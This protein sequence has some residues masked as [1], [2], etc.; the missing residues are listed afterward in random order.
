MTKMP[1]YTWTP[2]GLIINR[3]HEGP[4]TAALAGEYI[5]GPVV[6]QVDGE[7][8]PRLWRYVPEPSNNR[9]ATMVSNALDPAR[10]SGSGSRSQTPVSA[11]VP[12]GIVAEPTVP[13]TNPQEPY[14]QTY[15]PPSP[16]PTPT[17][18]HDSPAPSGTRPHED[19]QRSGEVVVEPQQT[20][21]RHVHFRDGPDSEIGSQPRGP[22]IREGE[23]YSYV[24]PFGPTAG[25][26]AVE[27]TG[28]GG[29]R[30]PGREG[31]G[32][33]DRRASR[34]RMGSMKTP[35]DVSPPWTPED[36]AP[37]SSTQGDGSARSTRHSAR[38]PANQ[39]PEIAA[40]PSHHVNSSPGPPNGGRPH[41]AHP[42]PPVP[43][44]QPEHDDSDEDLQLARALSL[45]MSSHT[46]ELRDPLANAPGWPM[47]QICG[48]KPRNLTDSRIGF[49]FSCYG[50]EKAAQAVLLHRTRERR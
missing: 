30:R 24:R 48:N 39:Q 31:S 16:A 22:R 50:K 12:D 28:Q 21:E 43:P 6:V 19:G 8:V 10:D 38:T 2:N 15:H 23:G 44:R 11:P 36:V 5:T 29:L 32:S 42:G 13:S 3:E 46:N 40:R 37:P 1:M 49:C 18:G 17:P 4:P 14:L 9:T 27:E 20:T 41:N 25:S 47:C 26:S 45:S 35:R 33:T 34:R 7:G